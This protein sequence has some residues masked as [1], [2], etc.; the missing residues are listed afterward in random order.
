MKVRTWSDDDIK[1]IIDM[2]IDDKTYEEIGNHFH[3]S[4]LTVSKLINSLIA[5]NEVHDR[6]INACK[7][8]EKKKNSNKKIRPCLKCR[9]GFLSAGSH[10]R[11]C[12]NCK[13]HN[14]RYNTS[15]YYEERNASG[16]LY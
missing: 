5:R 6:K 12:F 15:P 9:K 8:R 16:V 10:N 11:L 7:Q 1:V 3:A 2:Y 13:V 4:K 14:A